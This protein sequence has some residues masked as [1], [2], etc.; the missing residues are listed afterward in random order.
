M[1]SNKPLH[2]LIGII[3]LGAGLV[4]I[5]RET[6]PGK[7][8]YIALMAIGT[9]WAI[10]PGHLLLLLDPLIRKIVFPFAVPFYMRRNK[11]RGRSTNY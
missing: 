4:C 9:Y 2:A 10:V 11:I 8:F 6:P 5:I 1:H 7:G 3:M